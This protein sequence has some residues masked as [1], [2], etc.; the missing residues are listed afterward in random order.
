MGST[1]EDFYAAVQRSKRRA[2]CSGLVAIGDCFREISFGD[3]CVSTTFV[4]KGSEFVLFADWRDRPHLVII[5]G[6]VSFFAGDIEDRIKGYEVLLGAAV[7]EGIVRT[8]EDTYFT[9]ILSKES[10]SGN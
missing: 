6:D 10:P 7:P 3:F 5:S 8:N 9:E 1:P 2:S 4:P